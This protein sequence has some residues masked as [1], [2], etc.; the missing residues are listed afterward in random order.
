[1][2]YLYNSAEGIEKKN[3]KLIGIVS[4]NPFVFYGVKVKKSLLVSKDKKGKK[5]KKSHC[6]KLQ[7]LII[8]NCFPPLSLTDVCLRNT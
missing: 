7:F 8:A 5:Y 4:D 2:Q 6:R 3:R 1:M